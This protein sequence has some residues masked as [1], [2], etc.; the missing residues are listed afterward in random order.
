MQFLL[1]VYVKRWGEKIYIKKPEKI[2]KRKDWKSYTVLIMICEILPDAEAWALSCNKCKIHFSGWN[3]EQKS[4]VAIV[5]EEVQVGTEIRQ[6]WEESR[7][8]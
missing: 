4:C 1:I 6:V 7:P 2:N 5:F 3:E 8:F